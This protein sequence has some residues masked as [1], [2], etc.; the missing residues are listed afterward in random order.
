MMSLQQEHQ[1]WQEEK[2]KQALDASYALI[3]ERNSAYPTRE[4]L[5]A[6]VWCSTR[7]SVVSNVLGQVPKNLQ[8]LVRNLRDQIQQTSQATGTELVE[9]AKE[10]INFPEATID[11]IINVCQ[12]KS[13][14]IIPVKENEKGIAERIYVGCKQIVDQQRTLSFSNGYNSYAVIQLDTIID[15]QD[16][17]ARIKDELDK[18][19]EAYNL[20][21]NVATNFSFEH[22]YDNE[23]KQLPRNRVEAAV[24]H[25][26]NNRVIT[27]QPPERN[28]KI[29]FLPIDS[30]IKTDIVQM[31]KDGEHYQAIRDKYKPLA[32]Q[33]Q[34]PDSRLQCFKSHI[35]M[36]TY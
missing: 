33:G 18:R 25:D 5:E 30:R 16:L 35:T 24:K 29:K 9:Q 19:L 8:G 6:A 27:V 1:A 7:G 31:I 34:L 20:K 10:R 13:E 26:P 4:T 14:I 28:G 2:I 22:V 17:G 23:P 11:V 21:V 3:Q 15:S 12:G 32:D 36:K